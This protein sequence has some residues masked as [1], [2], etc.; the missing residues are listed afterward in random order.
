LRSYFPRDSTA[1]GPRRSRAPQQH[2]STAIRSLIFSASSRDDQ[3]NEEVEEE[4]GG[5]GGGGGGGE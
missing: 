5:G 3:K 4:G 1:T 2:A